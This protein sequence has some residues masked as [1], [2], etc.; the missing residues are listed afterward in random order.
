MYLLGFLEG[1]FM[2]V[3]LSFDLRTGLGWVAGPWN[4]C[5]G[6]PLVFFQFDGTS[7]L[8]QVASQGREDVSGG[9]FHPFQPTGW[10]AG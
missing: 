10:W 4:G 5:G 9:L 8:P 2:G 7:P 6:P 1:L 3:V